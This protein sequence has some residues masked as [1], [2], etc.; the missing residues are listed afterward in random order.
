MKKKRL[1]ISLAYF[2]ISLL[3]MASGVVFQASEGEVVEQKP[4]KKEKCIKIEN[5]PKAS[6]WHS[7]EGCVE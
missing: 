2:L 6:Q 3:L 5:Y 4:S 7:H 1:Y